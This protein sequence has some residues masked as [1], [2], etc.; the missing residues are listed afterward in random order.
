MKNYVLVIKKGNSLQI[1]TKRYTKK[2]AAKRLEELSNVGI[3]NM[4]AMH[5][6]HILNWWSIWRSEGKE[7]E[8]EH[9][10]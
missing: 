3:N 4:I 10:G 5:I 9:D 6:K 1:G 7:G 8:D 2:E